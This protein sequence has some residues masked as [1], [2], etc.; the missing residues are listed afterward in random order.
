MTENSYERLKQADFLP[1]EAKEAKGMR[2][3]RP[4]RRSLVRRKTREL[5]HERMKQVAVEVGGRGTT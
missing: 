4:T 1:T 2:G 5:G 3:W